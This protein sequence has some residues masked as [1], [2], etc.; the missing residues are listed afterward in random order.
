MRRRV[1]ERL[2][3]R[4]C[5]M[6]CAHDLAADDGTRGFERGT[7]RRVSGGGRGVAERDH[8]RRCGGGRAVRERRRRQALDVRGEKKTSAP[9]PPRAQFRS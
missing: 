7:L 6:R 8:G 9:P 4:S 5:R 2:P 1:R 3:G